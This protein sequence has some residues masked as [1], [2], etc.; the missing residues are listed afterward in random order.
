MKR[1]VLS[2][3][4]LVGTAVALTVSAPAALA[5]ASDHSRAAVLP[6]TWNGYPMTCNETQVT[7]PNSRTEAFS[8]QYPG[9]T[10]STS[11]FFNQTNAV[12]N[13]DF[14]GVRAVKFQI[15]IQPGGRFNGT[16]SY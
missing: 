2:G 6:S 5:T 10:G 8:C 13:S 9:P 4:A 12:W 11:M 16:A 1:S 3:A 15:V 14:D 7:G